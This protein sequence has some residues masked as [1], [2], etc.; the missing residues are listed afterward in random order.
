MRPPVTWKID[1]HF[2][3]DKR[4]R[5]SVARLSPGLCYR[6]VSWLLRTCRREFLRKLAEYKSPQGLN[7]RHKNACFSCIVHSHSRVF[8]SSAVQCSL[9]PHLT[10]AQYLQDCR[11]LSFWRFSYEAPF[12]N[13]SKVKRCAGQTNTKGHPAHSSETQLQYLLPFC[14]N[15]FRFHSSE[16]EKQTYSLYCAAYLFLFYTFSVL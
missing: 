2:A 7:R 4:R 8:V 1:A 5:Q 15:D 16:D 11:H 13:L 6:I 9:S 10:V 12:S 14:L 3:N